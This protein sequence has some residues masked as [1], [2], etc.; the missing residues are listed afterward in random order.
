MRYE[1]FREKKKSYLNNRFM[2]SHSLLSTF[3]VYKFY[4]T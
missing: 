3:N 4:V 2:I 1:E